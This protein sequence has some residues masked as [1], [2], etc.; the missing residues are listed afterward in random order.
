MEEGQRGFENQKLLS[1]DNP[2]LV[3]PFRAGGLE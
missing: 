1:A 2:Q 3:D